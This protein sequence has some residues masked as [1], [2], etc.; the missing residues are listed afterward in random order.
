MLEITNTLDGGGV[1]G[2]EGGDY[3]QNS[4]PLA[5]IHTSTTTNH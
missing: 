2:N 1:E 3:R 4:L 5:Y